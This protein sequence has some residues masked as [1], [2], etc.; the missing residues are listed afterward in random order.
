MLAAAD[1]VAACVS[2]PYNRG[3][4]LNVLFLA[5]R[6]GHIPFEPFSNFKIQKSST[7]SQCNPLRLPIFSWANNNLFNKTLTDTMC[8]HI[9]VIF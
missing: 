6:L 9:A 2:F 4:F 5:A 8:F 1:I 7:K 3:A